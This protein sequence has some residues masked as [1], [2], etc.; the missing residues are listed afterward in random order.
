[1]AAGVY[2]YAA[3]HEHNGALMPTVSEM[4]AFTV[5]PDPER[6]AEALGATQEELFKHVKNCFEIDMST[7]AHFGIIGKPNANA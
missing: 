3:T 1:M 5:L 7:L 4:L 6:D 2:Y